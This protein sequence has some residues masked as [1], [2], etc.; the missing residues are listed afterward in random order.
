[1]MQKREESKVYQR[2]HN[3]VRNGAVVPLFA[4]LLVPLMGMLAFSI[5]AGYMALAKADLQNA[6]DAA[7]LAGAEKLQDLWV[8]YYSPGQTSQSSIRTTAITNS[9]SN[10]PMATAEAF[11]GYN[12]AGNVYLTVPDAD[13]TFGYLDNQGNF[14]SPY[15]GFPNTIQVIVRRDNTANNP[16]QLFFGGVLGMSSISLTATARATIYQ[17][18]VS[19]LQSIAGVGAHILPVALDYTVWDQFYQNGYSPDGTIHMNSSNNTPQLQVYPSPGNAP[20]NFGLLDVGPPAN[21]AP[22]F[23]NWIDDGETPNDI[24]YLLN[25]NLLPVSMQGPQSWKGG[26]GLTSTLLSSFQS[27][28]GV[29]NLIPLFQAVQYPSASNGNTYIAASNQGQ[30]ATYAIVGFAGVTISQADGSGGNMVISIQPAAVVDPTAVIMGATPAGTQTS[31]VT[32]SSQYGTTTTTFTSA[33]L[34][35]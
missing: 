34:S 4:L 2:N 16:L 3:I 7:A 31:P 30:T 12:R 21:N 19:T 18:S 26:P 35:Y 14:T 13:V 10:S 28:M 15:S 23:R 17:G 6:A 25:N 9:G 11:A 5:D 22:A 8:Q 33:K 1:M 24:S 32:P 27:Q 20:G 29:P